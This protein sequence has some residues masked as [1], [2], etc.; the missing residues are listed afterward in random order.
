MIDLL[1][2]KMDFFEKLLFVINRN[3][4]AYNIIL[5]LFILSLK[6]C[7]QLHQ[8]YT[9]GLQMT[10]NEERATKLADKLKT[11]K[12]PLNILLELLTLLDCGEATS[13]EIAKSALLSYFD[14]LIKSSPHQVTGS[15]IKSLRTEC[16][17]DT[18]AAEFLDTTYKA[19][20]QLLEEAY[21]KI[22]RTLSGSFKTDGSVK[23]CP[24]CNSTNV[25]EG[26]PYYEFTHMI[27]LDC[28]YSE[29]ADD[30]QIEE[31][32]RKL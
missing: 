18:P 19:Y 5:S 1:Q 9:G 3:K 25:I 31:W 6:N 8:F 29:V 28:D 13:V 14:S 16:N 4:T 20:E 21:K 32:Y 11:V 22:I 17:N 7:V 10:K 27:C 12:S 26:E 23:Y 15:I 2:I 30:Y 24:K